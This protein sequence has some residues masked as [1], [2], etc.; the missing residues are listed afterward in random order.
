M[1]V[2][3]KVSNHVKKFGPNFNQG[4]Q[5]QQQQQQHL[6]SPSTHVDADKVKKN[7]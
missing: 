3:T 1:E 4:Q 5:Q 7:K 2:V 6:Y